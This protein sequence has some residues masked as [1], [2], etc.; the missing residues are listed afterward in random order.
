MI[1]YH[2]QADP[3]FSV[4]DT[5]RWYEKLNANSGGDAAAFA[6]LFTIPGITHCGGGVGLDRF[7][8]LQALIDW[9]EKGQAPD[10]II[11]SANPG[12]KEIPS[13]LETQAAAVRSVHGLDIR[14][15]PAAATSKARHPLPARRLETG[16]ARLNGRSALTAPCQ[17]ALEGR[18]DGAQ[19]QRR[20]RES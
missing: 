16:S 14:K 11:A 10:Q 6:R 8:A 9:V 7:D 5:I 15:I 19:R 2:G 3:V 20:K 17:F 1:I 12:N 18:G 13:S 4:N